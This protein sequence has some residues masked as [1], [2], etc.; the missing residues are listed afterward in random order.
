MDAHSAEV[1]S[2][3]TLSSGRGDSECPA[4]SRPWADGSGSVGGANGVGRSLG[5]AGDNL[6]VAIILLDVNGLG[7]YVR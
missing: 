1:G 2:V 5:L 6:Y 4:A 3:S 7:S